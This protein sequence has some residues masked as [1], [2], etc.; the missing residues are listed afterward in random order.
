MLENMKSR[1]ISQK[2]KS[3]V[4]EVDRVNSDIHQVRR[5]S[6][7]N[8]GRGKQLAHT[9]AA[10]SKLLDFTYSP[11]QPNSIGKSEN[12]KV[13][14]S[15]DTRRHQDRSDKEDEPKMTE[16]RVN[17][18]NA[19]DLDLPPDNNQANLKPIKSALKKLDAQ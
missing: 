14:E 3:I 7:L 4:T 5:S 18:E 17:D 10:N 15:E 16:V 9:P 19:N 13:H 8:F 11:Q 1:D 12:S 6:F 2:D